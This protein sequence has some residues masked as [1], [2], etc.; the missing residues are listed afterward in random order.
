VR[1]VRLMRTAART[2]AG[3]VLLGAVGAGPAAAQD[4]PRIYVPNQDD[5]TVSI[6]DARTRQVLETLDLQKLGFGANAK[7]HHVQV[8]P[9]GAFW[10]LTMI[11]EGKLLK[12]DRQNRIVGQVALEVPGL[13]ALHPTEDLLVVGR[14]MSAVNPPR[15]IALVRRSDMTLLDEVDVFFPRP[16]ALV[17]DP[18]G[19]Y[20][21]VA[22]LGVNQWASVRLED[23]KS[24]LV[25]VDGP[26]QTLT[27]AS[28]SPDGR[29]LA[30]T[31]Q[32]GNRLLVYDL[33][34]PEKPVLA[35]SVPLEKGP[36]ESVFSW[37]GRWVFVTNLDANAVTVLDARSWDPVAVIRHD[38]F[39]QPHG[40]ALSADGAWLFV[41]NRFQAG[42]AHD[43][44]GHKAMGSGN[45][46]AICIPTRTVA[47][48]TEVGHYAAGLNTAAPPPGRRPATP[49]ACR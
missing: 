9:G 30:I 2:L 7:P 40:V 35:Q 32:T 11:G 45:V 17:V 5:A 46:A 26:D 41:S 1:G 36:F 47:G 43:H 12:L 49:D 13:I 42:G 10:Y 28:I 15:R 33:T 3:L 14:S 48:V 34:D 19:G 29:R 27:Q 24:F 25:D 39:R 38:E 20:A 44:E 37:D 23:G 4:A 16:H 31:A 22:S 6:L 8:E 18:R 21:Y